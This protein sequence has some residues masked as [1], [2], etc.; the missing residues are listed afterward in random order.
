M[1]FQVFCGAELRGLGRLDGGRSPEGASGSIGGRGF[2]LLC[3]IT[4]QSI[5]HVWIRPK[6]AEVTQ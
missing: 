2:S 6:V 5:A 1:L 4:H 3:R